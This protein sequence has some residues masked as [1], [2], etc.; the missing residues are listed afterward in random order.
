LKVR[1]ASHPQFER[2][3]DD[4]KL[5]QSV[6]LYTLLLGGE[7]QVASL[8]KAVTLTIPPETQNGTSFRL[9][10]LGMPKMRKSGQRGDLFV[11]VEAQLPKNLNA[12]EQALFAELR[13]LHESR[14]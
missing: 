7:I 8:D 11:K 2:Q 3:G 6:D 1:V 13:K 5:T 12:R 10:G 9:R 14:G 4:L